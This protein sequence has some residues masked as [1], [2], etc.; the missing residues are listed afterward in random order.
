MKIL[1]LQNKLCQRALRLALGLKSKY[2]IDLYFAY[3]DQSFNSYLGFADKFFKKT[4]KLPSFVKKKQHEIDFSSFSKKVKAS[5]QNICSK[6]NIDLIHSHNY[7]DILTVC[8]LKSSNKL[9][10]IHDTHDIGSLNKKRLTTRGRKYEKTANTYSHGRIFTT[11]GIANYIQA[12]YPFN[13]KN[14]LILENFCSEYF[15]PTTVIKTKKSNKIRLVYQGE[16]STIPKY[17][18]NLLKIFESI[19]TK[20][21]NIEIHIYSLRLNKH[22]EDIYTA[23]SKKYQGQIFFHGFLPC[24]QLFNKIWKYDW[25]LAFFNNSM[26]LPHLDRIIATKVFDYVISGLPVISYPYKTQGKFIKDNKAGILVKNFNNLERKLSSTDM[27]FIKKR[28]RS[29]KVRKEFTIE[30]HIR[31]LHDFYKKLICEHN[32]T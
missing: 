18:Y 9:P 16:L 22:D 23:L 5:I 24:K 29:Y 10:I 21:N 14:D 27:E 4:Y 1:F 12:T 6:N 13:K 7:P 8:A 20:N 31:K 30:T 17:H 2:K 11:K 26:N 32:Q 25:G 28:L 15:L 19:V 3:T